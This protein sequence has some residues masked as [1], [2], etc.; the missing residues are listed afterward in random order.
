ML[1]EEMKQTVRVVMKMNV[2]RK[3]GGE[4]VI[5]LDVRR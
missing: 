1:W 5:E 3:R 2:V 4:R